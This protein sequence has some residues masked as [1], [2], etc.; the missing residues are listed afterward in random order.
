VVE[1]EFLLP[2][3]LA[4]DRKARAGSLVSCPLALR[5]RLYPGIARVDFRLDIANNAKDHRLQVEIPSGVL[6]DSCSGSTAFA[7]TERSLEVVVPENWAEYPQNTHPTHGFVHAGSPKRGVSVSCE[8]TNEF[9]CVQG[10]GQSLVRLTLLRCVGWLSRPDLLARRGN[11]GWNLP[12]P[13]AQCQ[14]SHGFE[15]G[16]VYHEGDFRSAGTLAQAD[17][18]QNAAPLFQ[19]RRTRDNAAV[20]ANPL[21][22]VS[23][24]PRDVRFS[25]LKIAQGGGALIFRIFSVGRAAQ[26]FTLELPPSVREVHSTSLDERR[27]AALDL[28]D[29][30][31]VVSIRPSEILSFEFLLG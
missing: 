8:S 7:V 24:L 28:R 3:A 6:V 21:P 12:S 11:G 23:T 26:S 9:E 2:E 30:R 17:R 18:K 14:G 25:A 4:Q 13:G 5:A 27:L 10:L 29:H 31:M 1:G 16:L 19:L 22:F 20:A 15:F